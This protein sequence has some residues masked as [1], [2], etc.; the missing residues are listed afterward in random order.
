M[1]K[2]M[3]QPA[4][5]SILKIMNSLNWVQSRNLIFNQF[6]FEWWNNNKN[7]WIEKTCQRKKDSNKKI[8]IKFDKNNNHGG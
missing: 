5:R 1:E 8:R 7:I 3:R 2:N 4:N 6:N